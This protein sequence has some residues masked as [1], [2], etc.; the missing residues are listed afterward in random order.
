MNKDLSLLCVGDAFIARKIGVYGNQADIKPLFKKIK[1]A[2]VS[3]INLEI[4][5]H[6]YEGFPI[7]EGKSDAYG[8]ADP[9]VADDLKELGFDLCSQA[10]NHAMDYS[11][12]GLEATIKNLDRV[13]LVHAGAGKN[14]AEAREAAYL[15]TPKGIVSLVSAC[16]Y[17]LGVASH[18]R[19]D[20]PGRPGIN[21]L[22]Y[23]T[24]YYLTSEYYT[25]FMN[26]LRQ[27]DV[28]RQSGKEP[29]NIRFPNR[30]TYF[31]KGS[32]NKRVLMPNKSDQEGNIKAVKTAKKLSDWCIF[33]LH[34]HYS[35]MKAPTGY[36][37]LELPPDEVKEFAHKIIDTG[38]DIYVGHGPHIM[39]GIEIYNGKPIFYSLG[40]FVFQSTLIRKQPGDLFD[41]WE[42]TTEYSTPE[43]Y[44][45]REAP[46]ATFFEDPAYWESIIAEVEFKSGKLREIRLIPI[47]LDYDSNKPLAE[48]RT[49]A[50]V[51]RLAI[52]EKAEKI[53]Q[54]IKHLSQLYGTKIDYREGIGI[55]SN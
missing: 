53:I 27:L 50:G 8:Q 41:Q 13:G 42:L 34:D 43:L 23:R 30:D 14:L 5:I 47:I 6:N 46:P 28:L 49:H 12:G 54:K 37:N 11:Y 44:E 40:N 19:I 36:R 35:G 52:G 29:E 25:Q 24:N 1:D 15:D 9:I 2:D 39:R 38:A 4:A 32:E 3:F 17:N 22:R 51:P 10:N 18:A 7:G 20:M 33:T 45:K 31:V 55:I 26:I 48:Q 16:T 21:P